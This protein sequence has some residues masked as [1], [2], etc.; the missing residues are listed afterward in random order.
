MAPTASGNRL[1]EAILI[2]KYYVKLKLVAISFFYRKE[3]IKFL[4][5]DMLNID[6]F[7][8]IKNNL[9]NDTRIFWEELL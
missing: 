6:M 2:T 7:D 5:E 3:Y 1:I 9:D 8:Y 4:Y